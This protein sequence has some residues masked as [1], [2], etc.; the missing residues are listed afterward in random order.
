MK[1]ILLAFVFAVSLNAQMAVTQT[2]CGMPVTEKPSAVTSYRPIKCLCGC[3][4]GS[5]CETINLCMLLAK[6]DLKIQDKQFR[7]RKLLG[8]FSW[9]GEKS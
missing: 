7:K 3:G 1:K 4:L 2:R 5:D 9:S 6:A 8:I